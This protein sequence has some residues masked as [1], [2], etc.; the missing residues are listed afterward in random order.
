MNY[1]IVYFLCLSASIGC[2]FFPGSKL[3][4]I[5]GIC[6]TSLIICTGIYLDWQYKWKD[7]GN[8]YIHSNKYGTYPKEVE[9]K[10]GMTLMPGQQSSLRVDWKN[11]YPETTEK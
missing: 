6:S 9:F 2:L 10:Q 7:L 1:Y 11:I 4:P 5:I 3:V 8:G